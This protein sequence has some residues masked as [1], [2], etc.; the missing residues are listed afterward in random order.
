MEF[1]KLDPKA[2]CIFYG[3]A[4]KGTFLT[5][6][7]Y[8]FVGVLLIITAAAVIAPYIIDSMLFIL[9]AIAVGGIGILCLIAGTFYTT[10]TL[11][12]KN[13][14]TAIFVN[15]QLTAGF[16]LSVKCMPKYKSGDVCTYNYELS[17][18]YKNHLG[19]LQHD[20]AVFSTNEEKGYTAGNALCVMYYNGKTIVFERYTT[21]SGK[22]YIDR[23]NKP[24]ASKKQRENS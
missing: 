3:K 6:G 21:L 9:P 18:A 7:L 8:F 20:F 2:P 4:K 19:A 5:G 12:Y 24:D 13:M 1:E 10:C 23:A 22:L 14:T 17:Y 11:R 16:L 15:G